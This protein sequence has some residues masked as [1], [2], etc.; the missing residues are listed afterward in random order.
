MNKYLLTLITSIGLLHSASL[1]AQ[2]VVGGTDFDTSTELCCPILESNGKSGGGGWYD[3]DLDWKKLCTK[4]MSIGPEAAIHKGLLSNTAGTT[5]SLDLTGVDKIFLSNN[6][7]PD[8]TGAHYGKSSIVAQPKLISPFLKANDSPNNMFVNVGCKDRFPMLSYN[9]N[10]LEPGSKVTLTFTVYDLFDVTYFRYLNDT[11]CAGANAKKKMSDFINGY[12]YV[13][14]NKAIGGG[15][16]LEF[17]VTSSADVKD[18]EVLFDPYNNNMLKRDALTNEKTA[19]VAHGGS[20][21]MTYTTTVPETGSLTFYFYRTSDCYKIPV[22]ID[23]IHVEGSIKPAIAYTGNPCPEQ[24]LRVFTKQTYPTGTK[25][26]WKESVTGQTSTDANFNF[27]PKKADTDYTVTCEVTLPGCNTAKSEPLKIHSGTCCTSTDGAPMAMTNLF[28]DDFGNFVSDD[29]YEWTDRLGVIHTEKLP[30]GSMHNA[31]SVSPTYRTP[32]ARAYNIESIGATL[33]VP[34][35]RDEGADKELYH[36]GMYV[37]SAHG[38][39]PSGVLNDNSGTT[40]GGML[41]FD[42]L[43]PPPGGG[44]GPQD[45]FFEIDVDNICTGKEITFGADFASMSEWPGCVEVTLEYNGKVLESDSKS[46]TGGSDGWK[47]VNKSFTINSEDVGGADHVT[48][49]MKV[50]HNKDCVPVRPG[51]D[52]SRDYAID[53]IVFQ[54]CTPPDVNVE[55]SVSTGKDILDLCTEDVLTLTSITSVEGQAGSESAVTRFYTYSNGQPDPNKK[56]GYVYQYTFQD[57]STESTTNPITWT[58]LHKEEVVDK[59]SFDVEVDKYWDDIFSHL[60]NDPTH[61]K[62]IYFRVVVGEYSDLMAD[63]S[64]KTKSA[65]NS[66]RKISISTIPVVAGLNCAACSHLDFEETGVTFTADNG[67]FDAKKKVVELCAGESVE[68][69]IKDAVHG[70]DKDGND[71]NDYEVKWFKGDVN[72]TALDS[73]KCKTGSDD[74]APTWTVSYDDVESAGAT[75]VKYII[76]FHDYFDPA[77]PTTSCDMTDTITVIANPKPEK[78][79]DDPDPFCEGTLASEPEKKISGFAI[80]WYEDKDITKGAMAAEPVIGGLTKAESPKSYYYVLTDETTGCSGDV[81]EYVVKVNKAEAN[82]VSSSQ[83]DYKKADAKNGSLKPLDKQKPS[84]FK[85]ALSVAGHTLMIGL[86]EG[87]TEATAPELSGAKF[88]AA[89]TTIPTPAVKDADSSDDEYLWYYT[90]LETAEGCLSDTILVPVV[91]KGAPSP[92]PKDAAYC[93]KSSAV[94]PMGDYAKPADEDPNGTLKFYGTDKTTPMDKDDLPDVTTPGKYTYWVSQISSTGGGESSKQ[95]I[96]IEVYG[97]ND[98]DLSEASHKYCKGVDAT[99]LENIASEK[100]SGDDYI[101]STGWEFFES[102]EPTLN[103]KTAGADTKMAV[104]TSSAGEFK[105][106]ARLKYEVPK[107]TEVCYGKHVEYTVEIQSVADPIAGTISYT[108]NEGKNGFKKPTDQDPNAIVGDANCADCSI[109]WY[110]EKKNKIDESAATPVYNKDLEGNETHTYYVKQVNALGCESD[111]QEVTIIVSGYPTPKVSDITVCENSDKLDGK[112]EAE[113]T[114]SADNAATDFTLYWYESKADGTMDE[115]TECSEIKLSPSIQKASD[116]GSKTKTYTYYVLQR[117]GTDKNKQ[118]APVPVRVT[119]NTNPKL[120]KLVTDPKCK[121]EKQKLS[122]MFDIDIK[123]CE[124]TY[125]DAN[126]GSMVTM[127]SDV[128]TEAG[129]Y[130]VRGWYIINEGTANE[131]KCSSQPEDLTVVFHDLEA[132][133]VGSDRT[134]PG[135]SVDLDADITVGGG[136]KASDVRYTWTNSANS[137]TGSDKAYDTGSEGL[138]ATGDMMKVTLTVESD[139]CKPQPVFHNIEVGDGPLRGNIS[140]SEAGN[141]TEFPPTA[142]KAE[143]TEF[144]SCGGKVEVKLTGIENKGNTMGYELSGTSSE[145]GTFSSETDGEATLSLGEGKYTLTYINECPTKFEFTIEDYSNTAESTNEKMTICEKENW[146]AE[147][148]GITGP[149]PTIEWQKDGTPIAG[150]TNAKLQFKPAKPEDSGVY[151]YTLYSAGCRFDGK[152][153]L[154]DALKVKPYVVF[155]ENSYEKSY[156]VVNGEGQSIDL[157]FKVPASSA[158]IESGVKWSDPD[159]GFSKTGTGVEINPVKRDYNLHVTAENKEY[160]KAETDIEILVDAKLQITAELER[161]EICEGETT[162]L[163]VDT[164]GTGRILH[165]ADFVFEVTETTKDG[166]RKISLTQDKGTGKLEAEVSPVHDATYTVTYTYKVGGQDESKTLPLKV[167]EKFQVEWTDAE[168]VCEGEAVSVEI[169]KVQPDNTELDWSDN[170]GDELMSGSISG[171]TFTPLHKK[172]GVE[173]DTRKYK[174]IAKNGI[175]QDKPFIIPVEVHKPIEG[176][177]KSADKICQYDELSLD[178]SSYQA[179][180]YE[181]KYEE[182]DSVFTGVTAQLVPEPDY[183]TFTLNMTRGK[184]TAEV[185]KYVEVTSAPSVL[186][187]DSIGIRQVEIQTEVGLGTGAFKYIIDGNEDDPEIMSSIRDGLSYSEHTV[188][189]IDEVGCSTEF[190]FVVNNPAIEIPIIISPNE[191]GVGD[192]FVVKG[193]AEGY[194][195]AKVTIFDRWGKQLATYNAGDGTDWD[196]VYNGSLMPSTDYWYEIQIKEIKK[197][198]TGHFTLIRQ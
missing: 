197:T 187:V 8:A 54:V 55:S 27:I 165:K 135:V 127:Q 45:D 75:G 178:A 83:I 111:F 163:V 86:V 133:I 50:R 90:Y 170:P 44:V 57:P 192:K 136:L 150:E 149:K 78:T 70:L 124:A 79:L 29:T 179:E 9:M 134:C 26:S 59:E 132:A 77:S 66:C 109:V 139:A 164:A 98:V 189:V 128:V 88:G 81:K 60:E 63:H 194:P 62:R 184:C 39:Y 43:N 162:K 183:A 94:K 4:D 168:P 160:C 42:L 158:D 38:G 23:N 53:N 74:V 153:A 142:I 93:V 71:Y 82:V 147:I 64:W 35:L 51:Q 172:D 67:K 118:S 14:S 107:S 34:Y 122:E 24:P 110:D 173:P 18:G 182:R 49:T 80:E 22:G 157:G 188:K 123:G 89:S 28:F 47:S 52:E 46:F 2:C 105:Y 175:C 40:T 129:L 180:T 17:G 113:A 3:E 56:V 151:T 174:V 102:N 20:A 186:Q 19:K 131:E 36:H 185:Q 130:E 196:G 32:C 21:N 97:V 15:N 176:E 72:S 138:E 140:F 12:N 73:K 13:A 166:G 177:I 126:Q 10:G 85:E 141:T 156:E 112:L 101:K 137:K 68:L 145:K 155:D 5:G 117:L 146:S 104:S 154:G 195:D 191:D 11:V 69:G 167:H 161:V 37:I 119:V 198:Y 125:Y 120:T 114:K 100:P 181:W 31:Q 6:L 103:E 76:S 144:S 169:T 48:I 87:A 84:S 7:N 33:N 61:E 159:A 106:Y 96:V 193:L 25:I 16:G 143:G 171:A 121:G 30:A 41:Q 115:S 58:T 1:S 99:P 92:T 116:D 108:K 95:P 152:I 91:I 148:T 65:F 190:R